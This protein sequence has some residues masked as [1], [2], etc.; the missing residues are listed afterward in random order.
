MSNNCKESVKEDIERHSAISGTEI[1]QLDY[2]N[3]ELGAICK[4]P[5]SISVIGVV[6][7]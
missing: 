5:F 2:P 4:K 1:V 6:K 7:E 3:D